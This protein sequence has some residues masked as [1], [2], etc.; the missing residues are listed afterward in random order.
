MIF[1]DTGGWFASV[2]TDEADHAVTKTWF[3]ENRQTLITT[4]YIVDE[5]LTLLRARRENRKAL[6]IGELFFNG[7]LASLHYLNE[8]EIFEAWKVYK[9]FSDKDWSF[10]DCTSKVVIEK[11]GITHA[12]SFDRH[13]KQFGN[14]VVV[15]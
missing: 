14:I 3:A 8:E 11:F 12:F 4:D 7:L 6:Q 13:F 5:T 15:P 9:S 1:F 10:T 2:V